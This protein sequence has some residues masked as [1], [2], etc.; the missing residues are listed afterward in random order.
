MR[1]RRGILT[2]AVVGFVSLTCGA[3]ATPAQR[4]AS[5]A[6]ALMQVSPGHLKRARLFR[7]E[8]PRQR[9]IENSASSVAAPW[10]APSPARGALMAL[11]GL[12]CL[13]LAVRCRSI[14]P[15]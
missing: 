6:V 9:T 1:R 2:A 15:I 11:V 12:G 7:S 8:E 13:W 3:G 4:E 10:Q 14:K 5:P